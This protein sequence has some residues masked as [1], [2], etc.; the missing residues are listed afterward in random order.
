MDLFISAL[1]IY[2]SS[3]GLMQCHS[4]RGYRP[5]QIDRYIYLVQTSSNYYYFTVK[6]QW[7]P[8]KKLIPILILSELEGK[9]RWHAWV[10]GLLQQGSPQYKKFGMNWRRILSHS[11]LVQKLP[12]TFQIYRCT[13]SI[14]ASPLKYKRKILKTIKENSGITLLQVGHMRYL[15]QS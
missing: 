8:L 7:R 3:S 6:E 9:S 11:F 15:L 10:R 13:G 4:L 2:Q 12:S 14:V 5:Q 1:C